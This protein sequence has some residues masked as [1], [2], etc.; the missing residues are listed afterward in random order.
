MNKPLRLSFNHDNS[1]SNVRSRIIIPS[2]IQLI[3][4]EVNVAHVNV[5]FEMY[6]LAAER[7]SFE[8][9][10]SVDDRKTPL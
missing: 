1:G 6:P 10:T 3:A 4:S 7:L 9:Q 2:Q 8:I 5:Q